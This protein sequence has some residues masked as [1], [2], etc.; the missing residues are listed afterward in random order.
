MTLL[1]NYIRWELERQREKVRAANVVIGTITEKPDQVAGDMKLATDFAKETGNPAPP[2]PMVSEYRSVFQ[3]QIEAADKKHPGWK[4]PSG[5][6]CF[7][8]T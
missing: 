1:S 3:Q 6:K 4:S 5:M 7:R 2:L 8:E